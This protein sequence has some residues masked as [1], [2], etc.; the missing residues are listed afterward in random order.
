MTVLMRT[1]AIVAGLAVAALSAQPVL[2]GGDDYDAMAD[3]EGKGPAYF[4]FVRD[5]RG[6]VVSDAR[7]VLRPKAGE[8]VV[9]KSNALGLYRSHLSKDVR[10]D[11]VE[12]SCEKDGYKQARVVRR[13]GAGAANVETNCTMQRL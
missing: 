11:E 3:A 5:H 1:L 7:V 8:P 12:V 9:L 10:P 13:S 2:A 6:S 4:G